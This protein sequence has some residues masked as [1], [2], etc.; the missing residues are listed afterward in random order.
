MLT[1]RYPVGKP[2]AYMRDAPKPTKKQRRIAIGGS[3]AIEAHLRDDI[4]SALNDESDLTG[5]DSRA[6]RWNGHI[7]FADP[8]GGDAVGVAPREWSLP[9]QASLRKREAAVR[10]AIL[11]ICQLR[12][13]IGVH[14]SQF[15]RP[16]TGIDGGRYDSNFP[17][18]W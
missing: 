2:R 17:G 4:K 13:Y 16:A 18:G 9:E 7:V 5:M 3:Y 15:L 6:Y 12:D 8:T 1:Q 14:P 10:Q 11:L